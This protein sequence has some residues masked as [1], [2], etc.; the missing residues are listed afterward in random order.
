MEI[1]K[2]V[3][4]I[5][6]VEKSVVYCIYDSDTKRFVATIDNYSFSNYFTDADDVDV[7]MRY[8]NMLDKEIIVSAIK[9]LICSIQNRQTN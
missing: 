1:A 4:Q 9:E 5:T 2:K 7:S 6:H 8:V 3:I